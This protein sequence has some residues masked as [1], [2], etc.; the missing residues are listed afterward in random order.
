MVLT[1]W[2]IYQGEAFILFSRN[3][4]T[5]TIVTSARSRYGAQE[6]S[7]PLGIFGAKRADGAQDQPGMG[8][9]FPA[10]HTSMK[11]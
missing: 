10:F 3:G 1:P 11:G 6:I 2:F 5:F 7:G 8:L 9:P 4:A